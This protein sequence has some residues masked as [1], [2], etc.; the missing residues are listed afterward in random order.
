MAMPESV[1]PSL[2]GTAQEVRTTPAYHWV[3]RERADS[4][5]MVIQRTISGNGWFQDTNGSHAVPAG[6]AM[7]FKHDDGSTYGYP[8]DAHE[9]YCLRYVTAEAGSLDPVFKRLRQDFGPVVRMPDDS[10]AT[11]LHNEL[12]ERFTHRSFRDRLH[13]AELLH[14]LLISIYREQVQGTRTSDPI[15]F[16]HHYL[17]S[18]FRS[19]INLKLVADKCGVSREHFIRQFTGR[20]HE[21]PGALL[22]RLRLE[23]AR[24]MLGSTDTDVESIALASGY[25]SANTFCRAFRQKFGHSPRGTLTDRQQKG[26]GV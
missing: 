18:H 14:S 8:A 7:L 13:E 22:R 15:E 26:A 2:I 1:F 12:H 5:Q 25:A 19:P 23:Q 24:A 20:Y 21:S 16:G 11:S 4:A 17:R 6:H 3:N 9:P 10:E